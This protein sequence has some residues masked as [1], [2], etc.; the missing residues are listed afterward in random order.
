MDE[1]V[2]Y[3]KNKYEETLAKL[4]ESEKN[5]KILK[6]RIEMLLCAC[7]CDFTNENNKKNNIKD[8]K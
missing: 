7:D 5:V 1:L 6:E 4:N 8:D 2:E 3:Y